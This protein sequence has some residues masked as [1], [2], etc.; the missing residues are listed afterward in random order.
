MRSPKLFMD[1]TRAPV[2]DPG[3]KRTKTGYLWA[4]ARE[5]GPEDAV[6]DANDGRVGDP[7]QPRRVTTGDPLAVRPRPGC[8]G[9]NN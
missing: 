4:I 5:R 1:E 3:R 9:G 2:L 8:A 6:D 7:E